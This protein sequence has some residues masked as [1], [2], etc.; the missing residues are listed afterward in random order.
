MNK[1][2]LTKRNNFPKSVQ[3]F[4]VDLT[5]DPDFR[6]LMRIS[7]L[8]DDDEVPE[9]LKVIAMLKW[10]YVDD[11]SRFYTDDLLKALYE[12][13]FGETENEDSEEDTD[14]KQV[15]DFEFDAEEMYASFLAEYG[16]DLVEIEYLHFYK[17]LIL[18]RG[19]SADSVL[20]KKI[21]FRNMD[22]KDIQKMKNPEIA[23]AHKDVQIPKKLTKEEKDFIRMWGG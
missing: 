23:K 8:A 11:V 22:T 13:I 5:V 19:L 14:E 17:F 10:F 15:L 4:G 9:Q 3:I 18:L 20:K 21:E 16:I 6:V 12:F 2:T 1:F 7:K